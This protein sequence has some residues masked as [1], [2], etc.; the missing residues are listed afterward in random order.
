MLPAVVGLL[1]FSAV[2][3]SFGVLS[4]HGSSVRDARAI[5]SRTVSQPPASNSVQPRGNNGENP[6]AMK[7]AATGVSQPNSGV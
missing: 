5:S 4:A 7:L 3:I 1:V 6:E 2:A